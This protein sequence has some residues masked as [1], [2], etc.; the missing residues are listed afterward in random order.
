MNL[1][2]FLNLCNFINWEVFL[3]VG[4]N[5]SKSFVNA[6]LFGNMKIYRIQFVYK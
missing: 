1:N 3:E 4:H 6:G 2:F 5:N